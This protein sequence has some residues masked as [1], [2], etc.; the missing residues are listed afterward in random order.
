MPMVAD[1]LRPFWLPGLNEISGFP[2]KG[3]GGWICDEEYQIYQPLTELGF[4]LTVSTIDPLLEAYASEITKIATASFE[5]PDNIVRSPTFPRSAAWL[6]IK[7]YYSAFFAAH[8]FLRMLG[9]SCGPLDREHIKAISTV[10]DIFGNAS[11]KPLPSGLYRLKFSTASQELQGAYSKSISAGPHEAFWSIFY[12]FI[13]KLSSEVLTVT[14]DTLA[15]R[16]AV[17]IKLTELASNLSFGSNGKGRW[18]STVRNAVNY[19]MKH[20]VWYP[21]GARKGYYDELFD[22]KAD[23]RKDPMTL[24]LTSHTGMDLRRF[25]VTCNFIVGMLRDSIVEMSRRCS[26]GRSFH[27]YGSLAFLNLS[28][29]HH[30]PR[31]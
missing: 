30:A 3:I 8:A 21:Y 5:T 28:E 2:L 18:L 31:R 17:S 20:S 12:E 6:I 25:Q 26:N 27:S 7:T 19:S 24:D 9:T 29:R 10:A 13:N 22:R 15:N 1:I 16:Q 23:W 4:V 11:P 14:V